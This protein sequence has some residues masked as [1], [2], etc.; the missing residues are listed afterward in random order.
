[1]TDHA[2]QPARSHKAP[3]ERR[4]EILAAAAVVFA[5]QGYRCTDMDRIAE[6]AGVGKGTVY[7]FFTNKET[8]FMATVEAAVDDLS[9]YV[10]SAVEQLED[11]LEQLRLGIS[12][13]LEFF[14]CNPGTVEL[15]IQERSEFRRESKPMYFVYQDIHG[16]A[17]KER[18]RVLVRQG[19]MRDVSPELAQELFSDFLYGAVFSQRLS[20][21]RPSRSAQTEQIV[22]IL[23]R[24]ILEPGA[25]AES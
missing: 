2:Q 6:Q 20:G 25:A 12:R 19:R 16:E 7:R 1:M 9:A 18:F 23:F 21:D 3:E 15:F 17:W 22:D 11:P 10:N 8:L 14:E 13:Y 5:E 4:R 24:G